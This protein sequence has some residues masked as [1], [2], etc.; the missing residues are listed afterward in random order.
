MA[1]FP[2]DELRDYRRREVHGNAY[3]RPEKYHLLTSGEKSEPFIR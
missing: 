3:R 2:V 1:C